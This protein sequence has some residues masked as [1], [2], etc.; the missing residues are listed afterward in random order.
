MLS[1]GSFPHPCGNIRNVGRAYTDGYTHPNLRPNPQPCSDRYAHSDTCAYYNLDA[2]GYRN[3]DANSQA[4]GHS[5]PKAD[6]NCD[7]NPHSY[8]STY[9]NCHPYS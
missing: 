6:R 5:D 4:N 9:A 7:P 1:H 3:P 8:S 2:N